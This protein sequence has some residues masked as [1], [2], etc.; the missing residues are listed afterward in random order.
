MATVFYLRRKHCSTNA[1]LRHWTRLWRS[2]WHKSGIDHYSGAMRH[3]GGGSWARDWRTWSTEV[4]AGMGGTLG[5]LIRA[6][7]AFLQPLAPF[8][9][10]LATMREEH[11]RSKSEHWRSQLEPR[12]H[13]QCLSLCWTGSFW[14]HSTLRPQLPKRKQQ[15]KHTLFWG[16]MK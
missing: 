2:P 8:R 14:A 6:V 12:G 13:V 4:G 9:W 15:Q 7:P 10:C 16:E 3:D 1:H 11:L 5:K